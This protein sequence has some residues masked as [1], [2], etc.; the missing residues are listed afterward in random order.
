M[1]S[2]LSLIASAAARR[3]R[4]A[5]LLV[6]IGLVGCIGGAVAVGGAFKD[7]FTVPGI[8]S[9]KAQDLLEQRFPAQSGTQATLVFS[10]ADLAKGK[11]GSAL[12]D[13]ERQPHVVSVDKLRMS[14]DGR[15]AYTTVSYDQTATDLDASARE[16]LEEATA[17]LPKSGI[18]VAMSG[19]P[20]DGAATGGFPIGELVGLGI[21]VLLLIA[22]LRSLRAAGNALFTAL[23]GVALGF[24]ALLWAA[25]ATDVPGLA[26]TLAGMLG[27]GAGIDYALLLSARQQEE[28]RRGRTPVE[29][30]KIANATAGHSA[31]T[32]AGIVLVSISGLLVTGIPFV[33][34]AGVA[35]GLVVL[36][37]AVMCV[38]LLPARFG[39]SGTRMLPRRDRKERTERAVKAPWATKRPIFALLAAGLVTSRSPPPRPTSS[40]ASPTTATSPPTRPSARPTTS[41]PRASAPASTGRWSSPSRCPASPTPR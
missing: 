2:L 27:L 36:A 21:A 32:A 3:P 14:E 6:L 31:I 17:G 26:P 19:E 8:E 40:S 9:Q 11:I 22:V 18:R 15:T 12:K 16:K 35:A 20:I 34:K 1:T 39:R 25:S 5:T 7:D 38:V 23:A 30:A 28:L 29:A 37:C 4:I 24:G 10:G 33:G 41:S 13:V